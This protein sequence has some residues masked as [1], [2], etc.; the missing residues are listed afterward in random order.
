MARNL[1][2]CVVLRGERPFDAAWM[3]ETF[4]R[5]WRRHGNPI[6]TFNNSLLEPISDAAR[7]LLIAQIGSDGIRKDGPQAIADAFVSTFDD[8][9]EMLPILTD[10]RLA[11]ALVEKLSGRPWVA[12]AARAGLKIGIGQVRQKLGLSPG[13][14]G[15]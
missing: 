15:A 4:E 9:I 1:V 2:E 5:F 12:A 14:P 10:T 7:D 13:H 3:T 8:P 11:H 6:Y